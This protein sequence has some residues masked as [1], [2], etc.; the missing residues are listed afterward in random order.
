MALATL[1]ALAASMALTACGRGDVPPAKAASSQPVASAAAASSPKTGFY[2]TDFETKPNAAALTDMG[3]ALFSE[4]A[5]SASG[6]M[7]CASC[8]DPAH[9]YGPANDLAV[10]FGG[11]DGKSP[12]VRAV[13]SLKYQQDAPPFS[14]HF[15]DTDGD[16]SVDQGP[17]GGRDWD[18]RASSAHEQAAG[19]LLSPYEMA[20][21]DAAAVIERLRQSSSAARFRQTFGEHVFDKPD[22]AWTGVLWALE[23]FQQS[24]DDFYPYSS[25]YDAYLRQTTTLSASEERG[26]K[27]FNA[28]DKGNCAS[29]HI[30]GVKRG[31]FPQFTDHGLI[32]IGVPRNPMIA[33]NKDASYYDLGLCGPIRGD[34]KDKPEY[35]GAFKTPSLRNVALRGSYFHNG[36]FHKLEDV[37]AFYA[38]RD[39]HP[40][41]FY[42][43][44]KD[45]KVRQYDDLPAAQRALYAANI[46]VD[47]PFDRRPGDKP[48]FS[49]AEIGDMVAFLKTLSDGYVQPATTNDTPKKP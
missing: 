48:A 15:S 34:M 10:Q 28:A 11:P 4:A 2:S 37:L 5:L 45:G 23:V 3:R 49:K 16:D 31:A 39:V 18:G 12:G 7:S 26:M 32:A 21:T 25:K 40:E 13:P 29:C 8:H 43:R 36:A 6:R 20:N 22:D 19:P 33:A 42:P 30:S 14:E 27:I 9:G 38:E 44:G 46:N 47:A 1:T 41:K 17:T 35:C 24:P